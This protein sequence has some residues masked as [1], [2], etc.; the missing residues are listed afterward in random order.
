MGARLKPTLLLVHALSSLPVDDVVQLPGAADQVHLQLALI[1]DHQLRGGIEDACA[2]GLVFIVQINFTGGEI[3]GFRAG[4]PPNFA[5]AEKAV[6]D[7]A[8][9]AAIRR[10]D[11]VDVADVVADRTGDCDV[12]YG[13]HFG[14]R[15]VETLIFAFLKRVVEDLLV[16]KRRVLVN[17][18][19]DGDELTGLE[20]SSGGDGFD[21]FGFGVALGGSRADYENKRETSRTPR[22]LIG[23]PC[24]P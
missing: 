14:E 20:I 18:E 1:I 3:V 19:G 6:G 12:A 17:A 8:N 9:L 4:V 7:E 22:K 23:R 24:M 2:L 10:R 13:A 16:G 21:G 5:K 15:V 11:H